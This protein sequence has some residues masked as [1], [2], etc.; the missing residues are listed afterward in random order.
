MTN[1]I[2]LNNIQIMAIDR[3]Q[4]STPQFDVVVTGL[5]AADFPFLALRTYM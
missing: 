4:K 1:F 3:A 5:K 2:T